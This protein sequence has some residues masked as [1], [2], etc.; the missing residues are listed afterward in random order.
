MQLLKAA[1]SIPIAAGETEYAPFGLR[2]MVADVLVY[3]LIVDSI[4]RKAAVLA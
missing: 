1:T 4:W 2:S 3:H